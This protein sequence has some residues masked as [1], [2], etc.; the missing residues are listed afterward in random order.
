MNIKLISWLSRYGLRAIYI[1]KGSQLL[2]PAFA[3]IFDD[4]ASSSL[5]VFFDPSDGSISL[6]GLTL[7]KLS[8]SSF[9]MHAFTNT[10]FS[11]MWL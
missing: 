9:N 5:D 11:L 1:A 10:H 7:G 6:P 4:A 2:P 3:S 8:L